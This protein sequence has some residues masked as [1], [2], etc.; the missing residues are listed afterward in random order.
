MCVHVCVSYK[1]MN[2]LVQDP[3][4]GKVQVPLANGQT[5]QVI[6][7][8]IQVAGNWSAGCGKVLASWTCRQD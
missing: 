6:L 2:E 7:A 5:F 3:S 1:C 8:D 4:D